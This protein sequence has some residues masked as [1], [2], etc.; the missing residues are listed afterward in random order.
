MLNLSWMK[1]FEKFLFFYGIVA[2]TALFVSFGVFSPKPL[3][4]IS[5]S[6][7]AP[8]VFYFWIRLTSPE[9][10]G[11]GKWSFRFLTAL[12]I[13]ISMSIFGYYLAARGITGL[14]KTN[15]AIALQSKLVS[16]EALNEKLSESVASLSAEL[17]KTKVSGSTSTNTDNPTATD[18]IF[19]SPSPI[20]LQEFTGKTQIKLITVYESPNLLAKKITTLDGTQ[21]YLYLEKQNN[22]YKVVLSGSN[23]GWVSGSQVR[24]VNK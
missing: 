14:Q 4:L 3:N 13:V 19:D 10:I 1:R 24:E 7:L 21:T 11:A 20:P 8:I 22:W 18:L 9:S 6:L 5:L 17:N 2:I 23:V 12:I 15:E 16:A